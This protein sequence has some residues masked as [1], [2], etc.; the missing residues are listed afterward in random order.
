MIY[1]SIALTLS[2]AMCVYLADKW[3]NQR[4]Q[5]ID[6]QHRINTTASMEALTE[7]FEE[8]LKLFND[9]INNTWSTT[10]SLKQELDALKL[11][12]SLKRYY[13]KG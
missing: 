2:V 11:S 8:Q 3:L 12:V 6:Y 1:L 10:S 7:P 13:L 9:R 5:E 4:Q